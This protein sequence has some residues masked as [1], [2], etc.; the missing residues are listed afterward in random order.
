MMSTWPYKGP[1]L[2]YS[3]DRFNLMLGQK[4][5]DWN[6]CVSIKTG[7]PIIVLIFCCF[8]AGQGVCVHT[9]VANLF[10]MKLL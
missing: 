6:E 8:S 2:H 3:L 7:M 4:E 10:W 9:I 5:L 1:L